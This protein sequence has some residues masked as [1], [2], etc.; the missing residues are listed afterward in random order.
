MIS[1][2]TDDEDAAAEHSPAEC[3][4]FAKRG[5][6][7]YDRLP[8]WRS[9]GGNAGVPARGGTF[10]QA[11]R[12]RRRKHAPKEIRLNGCISHATPAMPGQFNFLDSDGGGSYRLTGKDLKKFVGQPRGD[13]RRPSGKG[14]H[15]QNRA[16]GRRRTSPRRRAR[17]IRRRRRSRICRAAR[18]TRNGANT[19]PEFRVIRLR[20]VE[21]ACQ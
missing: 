13:R 20:G 11:T 15:V 4:I 14:H 19:L 12:R 18:L 5:E 8:D 6:S 16:A 10:A 3:T 21:G 9:A 17:S 2:R 1:S 7:T